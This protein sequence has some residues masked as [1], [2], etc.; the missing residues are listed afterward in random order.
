MPKSYVEVAISA[1]SVL[2]DEL[3]GL[4]TQLGF[5]GFWEDGD[6]LRCFISAERWNPGMQEEVES[7][8]TMLARSSASVAPRVTVQSLK[9][10]NWNEEWE[11]T[12]KPIKVSE[13]I[14]IRPSWHEYTPEPGQIVLT[15]DPKM[16]FGTGYHETTRLT[17][18]LMERHV[19]KGMTILDIGTGTG[20]LAIA[21]V[22][23]GAARAIGVDIDEWSFN[24]AHENIRLNDVE[25]D[26]VIRLGKLND[27]Q[28]TSFSMII[29]N[30]QRNILEPL[31]SGMKERLEPEGT[32]LLSG[33]LDFDEQPMIDALHTAGFRLME[34]LQEGEWIALAACL[35]PA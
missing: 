5:E 15:I 17:L 11:K 30:I 3:S 6:V 28:E 21:A 35:P 20:V 25:T 16:S 9:D 31:L 27:V 33:L 24:N 1:D 14:V 13:R 22:K 29:A 18:R 8:A 2:I 7:M 32:L 4:M 23:L 10:Q 19:T 12:I 26:V 34:E